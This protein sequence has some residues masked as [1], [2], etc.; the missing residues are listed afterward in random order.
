MIRELNGLIGMGTWLVTVDK[1]AA[2]HDASEG[3]VHVP[4]VTA[5]YCTGPCELVIDRFVLTFHALFM[6][7]NA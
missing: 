3:L 6:L 2:G 7:G 1:A 5:G 4:S